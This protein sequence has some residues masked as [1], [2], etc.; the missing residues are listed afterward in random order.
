MIVRCSSAG[1]ITDRE[2]TNTL[3]QF[4]DTVQE[5]CRYFKSQRAAHWTGPRQVMTQIGQMMLLVV[6]RKVFRAG[7]CYSSL[8]FQNSTNEKICQNQST[9]EFTLPKIDMYF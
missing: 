7:R 5:R 9:K 4:H 2:V 8:S 3:G 6:M 1:F